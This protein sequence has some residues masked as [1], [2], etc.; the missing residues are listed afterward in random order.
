MSTCVLVVQRHVLLFSS[1]L[2]LLLFRFFFFASQLR[3][4]Y[5]DPAP[6][7]SRQ[8]RGL[9]HVPACSAVSYWLRACL[10][11]EKQEEINK[12]CFF[13]SLFLQSDTPLIDH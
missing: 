2:S 9:Q 11:H 1:L 6:S 7:T 3:T 5:I 4:Q 8:A 10:A 12:D 13:P